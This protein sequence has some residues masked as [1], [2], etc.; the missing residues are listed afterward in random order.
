[1][2]SVSHHDPTHPQPASHETWSNFSS[3]KKCW[4]SDFPLHVLRKPC[5]CLEGEW[6]SCEG[7]ISWPFC[8]LCQ[9]SN[10]PSI[11]HIY[12]SP[13]NT[14]GISESWVPLLVISFFS[15][16]NFLSAKTEAEFLLLHQ[17][18]FWQT[19]EQ[20]TNVAMSMADLGGTLSLSR[21]R[22]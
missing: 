21:K 6:D 2:L 11:S 19:S 5:L 17:G 12:I 14:R 16:E 22:D 15:K 18:T 8:K 13:Y 3:T 1:M 10:C 4:L 9:L 7:L 20:R